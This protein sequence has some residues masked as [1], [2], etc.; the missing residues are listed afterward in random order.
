MVLPCDFFERNLVNRLW[1]DHAMF[2][3]KHCLNFF[4]YSCFEFYKPYKEGMSKWFN[5]KVVII[6]IYLLAYANGKCLSTCS[7]SGFIAI[8]IINVA[9]LC[10]IYIG[11]DSRLN[12]FQEGGSMI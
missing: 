2:L 4:S 3:E 10:L 12:P 11:I 1:C 5:L 9:R 6:S 8:S 7:F